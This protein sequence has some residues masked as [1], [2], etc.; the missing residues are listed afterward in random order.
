[1]GAVVAATEGTELDT[2]LNP[3]DVSRLSVFWEQTRALYAPFEST[4]RTSSADVYYHEMP[5]GQF[6]N[7]KFQSLSMGLADEWDRVK[8][9]YAAANRALGNIVKVTPSS[10]VVGDLANF[11]VSNGLDEFTLVERAES[12]SFPSSV[13]EFMQV[14]P[15]HVLVFFVLFF[16]VFFLGGFFS[17]CGCFCLC[18]YFLLLLAR[19]VFPDS[20][21]SSFLFPHLNISPE[22]QTWICLIF[23]VCHPET[24]V[25]HGTYI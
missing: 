6:T 19:G 11:M 13:I 16:F 21:D 14:R 24:F 3:A 25:L 2:G 20:E 1:M 22:Y 12:L 8:E 7:L 23:T 18:P 9:A 5:G 15:C 17:L 10:K 4:V